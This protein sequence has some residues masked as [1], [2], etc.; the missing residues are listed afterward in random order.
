MHEVMAA[1]GIRRPVIAKIEKPQAVQ[2]LGEI[3]EA[4]D[5][6]MVARGDLGV[7]LRLEP[8]PLV[9]KQAVRL[10]REVGKPVIVA[11]QMLESMISAR[12]RLAPRR[13]TSPTPSSTARTAVM[14]SGETSI[15]RFP[16]ESVATMG[17]SSS[18]SRTPHSI[19]S[20]G[21]RASPPRRPTPSAAPPCT[22]R[23]SSARSSWW[24][25]TETGRTPT[26]LARYRSKVPLLG[27]LLTRRC[28]TSWR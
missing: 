13:P 18:G 25:F 22:S 15:G 17:A 28:A 9:Q 1:E 27:S 24:P 16:V 20:R 10:A 11:T 4:F 26:V 2:H 12:G 21:S 8:V 5:G 6:I 23:T 7:E 14:L 19:G 3:L